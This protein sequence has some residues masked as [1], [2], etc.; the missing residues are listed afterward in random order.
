MGLPFPRIGGNF[1]IIRQEA[2][3]KKLGGIFL[4]GGSLRKG[5]VPLKELPLKKVNWS[6]S[7]TPQ[8]G[9]SFQGG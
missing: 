1:P 9:L 2:L 6:Y 3:A 4:I 5:K 7:S 8:K